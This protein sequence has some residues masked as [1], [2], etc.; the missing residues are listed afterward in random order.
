MTSLIAEAQID[1]EVGVAFREQFIKSRRETV[2][3]ILQRGI[4]RGEIR[5]NLNLELAIDVFYGA[6]WYRLLLKH[7]ALND[8][9]TVE[10][11]DLLM[12]GLVREKGEY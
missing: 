9:F 10:V 4:E 6:V 12:Q 5:E 11:V 1:P 3:I 7:A 2:R 8:E